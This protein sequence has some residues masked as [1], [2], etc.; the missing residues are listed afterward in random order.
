MV[1]TVAAALCLLKRVNRSL[2]FLLHIYR[3]HHILHIIDRFHMARILLVV[4][5]RL[6]KVFLVVLSRRYK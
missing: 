4:R 5:I 1:N 6:V 3:I 2:L